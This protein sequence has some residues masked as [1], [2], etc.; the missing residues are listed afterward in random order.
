MISYNWR[1]L[2]GVDT[3]FLDWGGGYATTE[4]WVFG[5]SMITFIN[6]TMVVN[7]TNR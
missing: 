3:G 1:Y 7:S 6:L 4:K 5:V 2:A